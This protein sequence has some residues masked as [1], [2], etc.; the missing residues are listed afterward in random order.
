MSELYIA[1]LD[2]L[3]ALATHTTTSDTFDTLVIGEIVVRRGYGSRLRAIGTCMSQSSAL[4][5]LMQDL[6]GIDYTG[7][8]VLALLI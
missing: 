8:F 6:T 3:S 5:L 1:F 4:L 7:Q 2:S